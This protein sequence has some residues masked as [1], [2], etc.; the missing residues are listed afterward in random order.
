MT[1]VRIP[2]ALS[3]LALT[4]T[5]CSSV[6]TGPDQV[7]LHYEGGSVSS[8]KFV[9][10]IPVSKREYN[11]PGDAHFVYPANQRTYD[12]TGAKGAD[13]G[14]I[15]IGTKDVIQMAVP[16]IVRF[17]LTSDCKALRE[18]HEKIG[19][20]EGAYFDD[21][22]EPS[23]GWR[24]VLDQYIGR[25]IDATLDREALAYN[26]REI[27]T[28]PEAKI[29]LDKAV[30]ESLQKLVDDATEGEQRYFN[31]LSV[32]LQKPEPP[33]ELLNALAS[34]Q[35]KIAEANAA[36]AEAEAQVATAGA[37]AQLAAVNARKLQNE[38]AGYGSADAYNKAKAIEKGINPYQPTYVV[39]QAQ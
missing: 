2:L 36:K 28:K 17:T 24:N 12:F 30:A 4:A 6:S 32:Q 37:Q 33:Q 20:R 15:T 39:P 3:A 8:K 10:C 22:A 34:E 1:H 26:W 9:D 16:G 35:T 11:G 7:A 31:I 38:I 27:Y 18:F 19:N 13:A 29:A 14:K 21:A 23:K 25:Q 5:A